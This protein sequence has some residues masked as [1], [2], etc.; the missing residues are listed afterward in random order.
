MNELEGVFHNDYFLKSTCRKLIAKELSML[1]I[2]DW[3]R[4]RDRY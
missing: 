1:T 4:P 3:I 2:S